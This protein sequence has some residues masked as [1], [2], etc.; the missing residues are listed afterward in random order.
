MI[1]PNCL[2]VTQP[3]HNTVSA[4]ARPTGTM[5]G[6]YWN[7]PVFPRKALVLLVLDPRAEAQLALLDLDL[8][9]FAL[10]VLASCAAARCLLWGVLAWVGLA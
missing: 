1:L 3:L 6:E 7:L 2:G 5:A 4:S 9:V 10:L 8:L